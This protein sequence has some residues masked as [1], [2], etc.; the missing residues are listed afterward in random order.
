MFAFIFLLIIIALL[1]VSASR[2]LEVWASRWR[3]EVSI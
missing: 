3:E 2:R 1:L